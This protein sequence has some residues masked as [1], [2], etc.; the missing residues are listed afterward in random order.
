MN[1]ENKVKFKRALTKVLQ[2]VSADIDNELEIGKALKTTLEIAG[3]KN[4]V[5][6]LIDSAKAPH[7]G[8]FNLVIG[9]V[10]RDGNKLS[11]IHAVTGQSK[12]QLKAFFESESLPKR[13]YE[14]L[15][16]ESDKLDRDN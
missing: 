12:E 14:R 2:N 9:V 7:E 15:S 11:A 16:A 10:R 5:L 4:E 6:I 1:N 3:S 13:L 8:K